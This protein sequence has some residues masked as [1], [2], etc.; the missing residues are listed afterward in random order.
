[1]KK[2]AMKLLAAGAVLAGCVLVEALPTSALMVQLNTGATCNVAIA[3]GSNWSQV[4]NTGGCSAVQVQIKNNIDGTQMVIYGGWG[5]V[6]Y[7]SAA[8]TRYATGFRATIGG[9]T[10][11]WF[12]A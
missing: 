11:P 2:R 1:M 12:S 5:P 3:K 9:S 4:A 7:A 10:S 6:S 8:G